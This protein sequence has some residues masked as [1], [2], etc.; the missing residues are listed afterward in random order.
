MREFKLISDDQHMY[1][2]DWQNWTF[3]FDDAKRRF[4]VCHRTWTRR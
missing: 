1:D 3:E 4:G 2:A